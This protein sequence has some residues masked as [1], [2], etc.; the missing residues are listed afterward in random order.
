MRCPTMKGWKVQ[1][2]CECKARQQPV[3]TRWWKE[4][5][6]DHLQNPVGGSPANVRVE[7]GC[8]RHGQWFMPA[9]TLCEV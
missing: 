8:P 4:C 9:D 7:M 1:Q 3:D 5:C 2:F 6:R